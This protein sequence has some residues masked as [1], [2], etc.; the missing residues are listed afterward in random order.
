MGNI[1]TGDNSASTTTLAFFGIRF[2][3]TE[4]ESKEGKDSFGTQGNSLTELT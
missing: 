4:R 3:L 2:T 1:K